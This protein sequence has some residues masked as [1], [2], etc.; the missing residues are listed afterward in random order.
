MTEECWEQITATPDVYDLYLSKLGVS[1]F[2]VN[3]VYCFEEEFV[4][5]AKGFLLVLPHPISIKTL[6]VN[7]T[8][9]ITR[10]IFTTQCIE[11]ICGLVGIC[12][13]L[14][15]RSDVK[16]TEDGLFAQFKKQVLEKKT[17]EERGP[18]YHMFKELHLEMAKLHTNEQDKEREDGDEN[19]H[20]I[21][22]IEHDNAIFVLDGRKGNF[23]VEERK[24][25]MSFTKQAL[26]F[27]QKQVMELDKFAVL[28]VN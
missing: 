18:I 10:P 5:P 22:V 3:E 15:N 24:A 16:Y 1:N 9:P 2:N 25:E 17:P 8:T 13:I 11:N 12:H 4:G 23:A 7:N 27:I 14:L 20:I 19:Y 21:A 26:E 6:F 28:S